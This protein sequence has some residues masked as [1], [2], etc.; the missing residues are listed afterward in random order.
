MKGNA[1]KHPKLALE[2]AK[3]N[4]K[5]FQWWIRSSNNPPLMFILK[6]ESDLYE[7]SVWRNKNSINSSIFETSH[8]VFGLFVKS[9]LLLCLQVFHFLVCEVERVESST[10]GPQNHGIYVFLEVGL[11]SEKFEQTSNSSTDHHEFDRVNEDDILVGLW[12]I[13]GQHE[14]HHIVDLAKVVI[15]NPH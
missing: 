4:R 10:H 6:E 11:S 8:Q 12:V 7:I 9:Q 15:W 1:K 2:T 14:R 13:S 3:P 5:I